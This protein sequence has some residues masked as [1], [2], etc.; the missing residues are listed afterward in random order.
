MALKESTFRTSSGRPR[1][2][3]IRGVY[4]SLLREFRVKR[5][6]LGRVAS[7]QRDEVLSFP[8]TANTYR[9][10]LRRETSRL[11]PAKQ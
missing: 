3:G 4:A 11:R 5:V 6:D 7:V 9:S 2:L 1:N 10:S 8:Q